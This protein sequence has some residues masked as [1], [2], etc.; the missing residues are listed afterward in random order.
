MADLSPAQ[1]YALLELLEPYR[2]AHRTRYLRLFG[3]GP[4]FESWYPRQFVVV[5]GRLVRE[6]GV[7]PSKRLWDATQELHA[8]VEPRVAR[9]VDQQNKRL[10]P[11]GEA[12][13][14][15]LALE[16]GG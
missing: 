5:I 4:Y 12:L 15:L 8:A 11:E 1:T 13:Y 7:A 14:T 2:Q 10:T 9:Y 3:G 6:A 16:E